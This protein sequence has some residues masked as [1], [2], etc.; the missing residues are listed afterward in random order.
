[1]S[2]RDSKKDSSP[3]SRG[4]RAL[5]Y[6]PASDAGPLPAATHRFR[7][8]PATPHQNPAQIL[9]GRSLRPAAQSFPPPQPAPAARLADVL[10]IPAAHAKSPPLHLLKAAPVG[11]SARRF[12]RAPKIRSARF[13]S[14][15][16]PLPACSAASP[17]APES[18]TARSAA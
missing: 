7:K 18:H 14:L 2:L 11:Y 6:L 4:S 1:M 16:A 10:L 9:L 5:T 8:T 17:R 3:Q 15:R 12:R 13:R